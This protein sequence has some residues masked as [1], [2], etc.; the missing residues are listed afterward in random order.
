V[1][2][3]FCQDLNRIQVDAAAGNSPLWFGEWGL[4]TQFNATDDFLHQWADAQKLAYSKGAGW[5][6]RVPT[7]LLIEALLK[8]DNLVLELQG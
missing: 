8:E 4:P 2:C 7:T 1:T 5:I 6:V 3:S